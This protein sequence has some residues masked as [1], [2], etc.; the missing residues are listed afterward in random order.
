MA[1][2]PP[3]YTT[4]SRVYP[5][6][7]S[8]TVATLPFLGYQQ[9]YG[10]YS[11][12]DGFIYDLVCKLDGTTGATQTL[13][14]QSKN[15]GYNWS[16]IDPSGGIA[17]S[18]NLGSI[19]STALAWGFHRPAWGDHQDYIYNAG[20]Y[21]DSGPT[22]IQIKAFNLAIGS[23]VSVATGGP[24]PI[25]VPPPSYLFYQHLGLVRRS[26]NSFVVTWE[27]Q[28]AD[29]TGDC[30]YSI[31]DSGGSWSVAVNINDTGSGTSSLG[32]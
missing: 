26:D 15:S 6:A 8:S 29:Y 24:T 32:R 31:C 20:F 22:S 7:G 18:I 30:F 19:D 5:D 21:S 25:R 13:M 28:Y 17:G 11:Y 4:F 12:T 16:S 2:P 1:I 23:W 3:P 9:H 14:R 27:D 10:P